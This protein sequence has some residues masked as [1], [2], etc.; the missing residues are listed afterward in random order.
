MEQNDYRYNALD[1][2]AVEQIFS[3]FGLTSPEELDRK[4]LMGRYDGSGDL[5]KR[6]VE[7]SINTLKEFIE[8]SEKIIYLC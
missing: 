6:V 2:L 4:V 8:N 5:Y 1:E 7:I 3:F